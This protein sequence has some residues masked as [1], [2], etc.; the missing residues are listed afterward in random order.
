MITENVDT[1]RLVSDPF[2]G[3]DEELKAMFDCLEHEFKNHAIKGTGLSGIQVNL[4]Y[5]V[6]IIRIEREYEA[7]G[8][9]HKSLIS[10]NLYNAE[11]IRQEQSF[12][13][14]G[15]GCLS[16][17]G[18]FK[19]TKRFN[20]IEIKNGNGEIL[21]FSGFDAVVVSHEIDHWNGILFIDRKV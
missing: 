1:L 16:V 6:A 9:K 2:S 19:N 4:P 10:H 14:K 8:Q 12:V 5:R 15:E 20:L 18:E 11:I 13:F 17:P 7:H 3:T 21:K